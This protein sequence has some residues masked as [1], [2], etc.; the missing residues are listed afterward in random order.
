MKHELV[1]PTRP[2]PATSSWLLSPIDQYAFQWVIQGT[3]VFDA[4]L[5]S[6]MVKHGLARLLD[7]YPIL[8]GRVVG[9]RRIEWRNTGV[10]VIEATD[11]TLGVSDF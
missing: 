3:W 1:H 6:N 9:G 11:T 5:D 4:T 8:C 10:P 7:S 2:P